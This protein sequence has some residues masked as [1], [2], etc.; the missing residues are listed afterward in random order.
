M[1]IKTAIIIT[2]LAFAAKEL[3]VRFFSPMGSVD[4]KHV[5]A[6]S[7]QTPPSS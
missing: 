1:K 2:A 4:I 5:I 3:F 6:D 7:Q